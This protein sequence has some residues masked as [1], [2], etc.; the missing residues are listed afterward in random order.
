M[1]NCGGTT[2]R[3]EYDIEG[4]EEVS[5]A[6]VRAVSVLTD[7]EPTTLSA[8]SKVVDTA[9]LDILC[10][11]TADGAPR[12]GAKVLFVYEQCRITVDNGEY[13]IVEPL[14]NEE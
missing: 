4:S 1:L 5:T 3:M 10:A 2:Y 11:D 12:V 8:L 9:A 13:L 6:V 14:R 7:R